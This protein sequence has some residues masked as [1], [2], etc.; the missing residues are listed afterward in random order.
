VQNAKHRCSER[1]KSLIKKII[2]EIGKQQI[3]KEV[4]LV[5]IDGV[6]GSGKTT[7]AKLLQKAFSPSTIVQLDDFYSPI[8][9]AADLPRLKDQVIL[10]LRDKKKAKYQV[11]DWK[12]EKLSDWHTV[13]PEGVI[14]FEGVFALDK[15]IC[16]YYDIRIWIEYP[17]ELGFERG[18]AR[19]I[20][21]DGVDNSEKW[22][23]IWM[24]LEKKY[25]N[26]QHPME[27]A[28]FILDGR[29]FTM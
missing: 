27:S 16:R 12:S 7:L 21:G 11:Y 4:I 22:K 2:F 15:Q 28:D 9:Q 29:K 19:D 5:A 1:R 20:A 17:A 10:P 13:S 24:P 6:G 18:V 14:I 26:E 23:K 25:I 8:L 3:Q